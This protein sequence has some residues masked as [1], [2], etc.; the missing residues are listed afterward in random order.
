MLQSITIT[1]GTGQDLHALDAVQTALTCEGYRVIGTATSGQAAR[2]LGREASVES[3]TVASLL[4]RLDRGSEQL[5][6]R[7]VV[8]LDEAGMT[9]DQDLLRLVEATTEA[10]AKLV[11]VGDDRQ[12]SAVGPGGSLAALVRRFG[13]GVWRLDDNI[14][15][16]DL[17]EREA[18]AEMR[19][20]DVEAAVDWLRRNDRIEI[21]ADRPEAIGAMVDGW[22]ADVEKG[23]D[24]VMLAWRRS[25]VDALNQLGREAYEERGWLAGPE[26]TAPG[27]RRYRA[28]DRVVALAPVA[29]QVVTSE[30]GTVESVD[31]A[32]GSLTVLLDEGRRTVFAG[33]F[34]SSQRLAHAYAVTVH[35]SQGAT[36]DTAHYLEEGGGRELAYVGLS[37]ARRRSTAYAVADDLDQ[38]VEDFTQAWSIERRQEWVIGTAYTRPG[39]TV[40]GI[41]V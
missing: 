15:Q 25:S 35:R 1:A 13:G 5:D 41:E 14:R 23:L 30:V 2:T 39:A 22:I 18:L 6:N 19:S 4:A 33:P 8:V 28:G 26:I 10:G 9:N 16:I 7:T 11:L 34:T 40:S 27:G 20:G 21:G 38:A 29:G 37:R 31:A 24:T 36:V 32:N 12:L 3:F 17:A